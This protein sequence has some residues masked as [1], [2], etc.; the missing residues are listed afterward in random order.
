[1]RE[2]EESENENEE[3]QMVKGLNVEKPAFKPAPPINIRQPS[4]SPATQ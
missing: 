2:E 1:M 3:E 4:I